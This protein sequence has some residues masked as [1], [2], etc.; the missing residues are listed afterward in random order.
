MIEVTRTWEVRGVV[1]GLDCVM[2]VVAVARSRVLVL[3]EHAGSR[4]V[5]GFALQQLG[6]T[7]LA[8]DT[9]E[10][11]LAAL[12][13]F[14]PHAVIYEWNL[15]KGSGLGLARRLRERSKDRRLS[16]VAVSSLDEPSDFRV[17]EPVDAYLTK[18]FRAAELATIVSSL[19]R[20]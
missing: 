19:G 3:D 15:R 17:R 13:T 6:C 18:P 14:L 8:V 11:A 2:S 9:C 4:A 7:Q 10:A 20:R 1:V 16:I 5:M 12:D